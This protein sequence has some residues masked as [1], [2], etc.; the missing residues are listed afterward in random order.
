[1]KTKL[2]LK[3]ASFFLAYF[4]LLFYI[5]EIFTLTTGIKW[6]SH[7]Q[8]KPKYV[9][10][11]S[12]TLA[13]FAK[14]IG[15]VKI[16][17][18]S[19]SKGTQDLHYIEPR[20]S[21]VSKLRQADMVALN[22]L[23]FDLWMLPLIDASRNSRIAPGNIGYID[24]ST[25]V[26]PLEVPMGKVS[27][28][29]GELHPLGNPHYLLDPERAKVAVKN[30]FNALLRISPAD[31]EFF[32]L[33]YE[34]YIQTLNKKIK[35]WNQ[36]MLPHK[37]KP[38]V[39]YHKSWTYFIKGF[40]LTEFGTIEDKPAIPP[41]PSHVNQLIKDMKAANIKVILQEPYFPSKFPLLIARE[42]NAALLKLPEWVGGAEGL[43]TYIT[44][45]DYLVNKVASALN[46][47]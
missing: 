12:T 25:G 27:M 34:K 37:G 30:I 41:S 17:V 5:S 26:K 18:E 32:R 42:T 38:V 45:M 29:H 33:N 10:T 44:L 6:Q 35:E 31:S 36:I 11:S 22:G 24:A 21:F 43:N 1:M 46:S 47:K 40:G 19:F 23:T 4:A 8:N 14:E 3:N 2:F 9:I 15:G 16:E 28:A 13:D 7:A 20:P 39:T